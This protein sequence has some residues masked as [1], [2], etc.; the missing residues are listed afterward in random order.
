MS[1]PDLWDTNDAGSR[2]CAVPSCILVAPVQLP[3]GALI[4]AIEMNACD[5]NFTLDA[6]VV[7]T[8]APVNEGAPVILATA[9][10]SGLL[11][12]TFT[13]TLVQAHTVDNENNTYSLTYTGADDNTTKLQAVRVYYTL[14]T[15]P[16]PAV[17]TFSDV[18]TNHPFF[19]FIEAMAA[20]GVTVGCGGGKY[21]PD[22]PVTRGQMAVFFGRALGLHFAP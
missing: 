10:T 9:Q 22:D 13:T 7:F 6:K 16:A 15:S 17:A 19:R 20:S 1:Y 14:Q 12:C 3:A 5:T 8:Q 18:P 4:S 21:C 2:S 11:G